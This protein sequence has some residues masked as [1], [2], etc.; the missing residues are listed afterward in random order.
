MNLH[1]DELAPAMLWVRVGLLFYYH[2]TMGKAAGHPELTDVHIASTN[3]K[4]IREMKMN[5]SGDAEF[6]GSCWQ[7]CFVCCDLVSPS[8]LHLGDPC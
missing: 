5:P 7:I 3:Q 2:F 1:Q 8:G 6:F 4:N